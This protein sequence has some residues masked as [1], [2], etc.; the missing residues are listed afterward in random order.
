MRMPYNTVLLAES[1]SEMH[2]QHT[3]RI[4]IIPPFFDIFK[5]QKVQHANKLLCFESV[6]MDMTA[7]IIRYMKVK[8]G[9]HFREP[10]IG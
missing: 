8:K 1:C 7:T 10:K 2:K 9:K 4:I 6:P 3:Y 5:E